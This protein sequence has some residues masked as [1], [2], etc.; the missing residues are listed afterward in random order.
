MSKSN[1]INPRYIT[2]LFFIVLIIQILVTYCYTNTKRFSIMALIRNSSFVIFIY[3]FI[4]TKKIMYLSFPFIIEIIFSSLKY[5]GY[6]LD[7]YIATEYA[8]SDYFREINKKNPIYSNFS[9]GLYNNVFGINTLD[10]SINNLKKIK[11]WSKDV[12]DNSYKNK[13]QQIIGLN[14]EHFN[15]AV[16]LK[17]LGDRNKFK[18]ICEI[19]KIHKDMK[20]LEIGFGEGDFMM[21]IKEHYGI[22]PVGVSISEE[23]VKLVKNR[24]FEAYHMNMWDITNKIGQFDLILQCGNLEYSR[25]P[26]ESENKYTVY[27]KIIQSILNKNGKYFITCLHINE[28]IMKRYTLYDWLRL[29]LLAFGNDG[30]YPNGRFSLTKHSENAKLKNI[31]QKEMTNDYYLTS[32]FFM[33]TYGFVNSK[34][35]HFTIPSLIEAIIKT[36]AAP[37]YIHTY[38]CY[39]PTKDY[40]WCPWLWEFVPRQRG[41]WFGQFVT[42]EYILFQNTE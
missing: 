42:L 19:C 22:S 33:S 26:Y 27:F 30:A 29:Y 14:G 28:N 20:I 3:L 37:Y 9:E 24:G 21:Y 38:L 18:K 36:I 10:H 11:K 2:F 13:T 34:N 40:Y 12:Y 31:Y 35:N 16:E 7:K 6:Q 41:D 1:N 5:H 15:D 25:C 39:T 32:V 8:Y 4:K 23:Q 17:K